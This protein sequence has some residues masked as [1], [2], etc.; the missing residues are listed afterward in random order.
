MAANVRFGSLQMVHRHFISRGFVRLLHQIKVYIYSK[1]EQNR[2]SSFEYIQISYQNYFSSFVNIFRIVKGNIRVIKF[3]LKKYHIYLSSLD[4]V[5]FYNTCEKNS[6]NPHLL[7]LTYIP[8]N[9]FTFYQ[10]P[11]VIFTFLSAL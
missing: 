7:T 9:R 10:K 6:C 2:P 11:V 5:S 3:Y 8:L 1:F 4:I